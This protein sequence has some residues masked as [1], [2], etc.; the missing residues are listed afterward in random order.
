MRA[1]Q[2]RLYFSL[3]AYTL[4][5][6]LRRLGLRGTDIARSH[7]NTIR[8]KLLKTGAIVRVTVRK[9]WVSMASGCPYG[10]PVCGDLPDRGTPPPGDSGHLHVLGLDR[11]SPS[12]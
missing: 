6:A 10:L 4:L 11:T 12:Y 5:E 7:C 8:T 2:V 9:I 1:N 3:I